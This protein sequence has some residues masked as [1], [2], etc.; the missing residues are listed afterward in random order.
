M[1]RLSKH[2]NSTMKLNSLVWVPHDFLGLWINFR[3]LYGLFL[4]NHYS[5]YLNWHYS[6][7]SEHSKNQSDHSSIFSN[8][9]SYTSAPSVCL[10]STESDHKVN[11]PCAWKIHC[12][13]NFVCFS[14]GKISYT[15]NVLKGNV[16]INHWGNFGT[17]V[18]NDVFGRKTF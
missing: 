17:T 7:D 4:L 18:Q 10:H 14:G 6:K 12:I 13:M 11:K 9:Y 16:N 3:Y 15:G 2:N 8:E 1:E 5:A